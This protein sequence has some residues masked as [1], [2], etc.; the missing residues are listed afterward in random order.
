VQYGFGCLGTATLFRLAKWGLVRSAK[1]P[2]EAS[3]NVR[4]AG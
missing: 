2:A 3:A 1:F 4:T